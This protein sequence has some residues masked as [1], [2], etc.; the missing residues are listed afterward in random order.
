MIDVKALALELGISRKTV[1]ALVAEKQIP[2][3]RIGTGRGTI[4]FDLQEVRQ[5]LKQQRQQASTVPLPNVTKRHLF[6]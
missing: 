3:Y 2:Y 6:N 1:Y 5:S 4:R